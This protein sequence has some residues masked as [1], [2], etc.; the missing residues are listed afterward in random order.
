MKRALSSCHWAMLWR[1]QLWHRRLRHRAGSRFRLHR[2]DSTRGAALQPAAPGEAKESKKTKGKE[3]S[4]R[5]KHHPS[6]PSQRLRQRLTIRVRPWVRG[7]KLTPEG[8]V[9]LPDNASPPKDETRAKEK[10]RQ[11]TAKKSKTKNAEKP[12]HGPIKAHDKTKG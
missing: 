4:R 12:K 2:G 7:R 6:N 8:Q 11:K 9:A 10:R 5:E 1:Y 3:S